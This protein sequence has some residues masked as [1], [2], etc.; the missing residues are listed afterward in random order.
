M[1][2]PPSHSH[3]QYRIIT[4][5][6]LCFFSSS[7]F[8]FKSL[9]FLLLI[10][11]PDRSLTSS[12]ECGLKKKKSTRTNVHLLLLLLEPGTRRSRTLPCRWA[13]QTLVLQHSRNRRFLIHGET[14][15]RR[16]TSGIK[17][18]A[19][20][21]EMT[22]LQSA[23]HEWCCSSSTKLLQTGPGNTKPML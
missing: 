3:T 23:R 18:T 5:N 6:F 14:R 7:S 4:E 8:H 11:T 10:L 17:Q 22:P 20:S 21:A 16:K 19:S 15:G 13:T 2:P 12:F 1:T 9:F